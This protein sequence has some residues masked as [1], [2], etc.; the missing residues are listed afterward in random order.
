MDTQDAPLI[1]RIV[2]D[3]T[4]PLTALQGN[5]ELALHFSKTV[6]EVRQNLIEAMEESQRLAE[7]IRSVRGWADSLLPFGPPVACSLQ[8]WIAEAVEQIRPLGDELARRIF[9]EMDGPDFIL[10]GDPGRLQTALQLILDFLVAGG[11]DHDQITVFVQ[12]SRLLAAVTIIGRGPALNQAECDSLLNEALCHTVVRRISAA[13]R[14]RLL[15]AARTLRQ[16][17]ASISARPRK[18]AGQLVIEFSFEQ[19]AQPS[20]LAPS[21]SPESSLP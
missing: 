20:E 15:A 7:L 19:A 12:A 16:A 8:T 9:L 1:R 2:H 6:E 14:F 4:Q 10:R 21:A 18:D 11:A 5:M 3:L 13:D 17:G